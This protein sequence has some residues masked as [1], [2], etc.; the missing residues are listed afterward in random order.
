VLTIPAGDVDRVRHRAL[1]IR[2]KEAAQ[3]DAVRD[4]SSLR[5]QLGLEEFK[6]ERERDPELTFRRHLAERGAAIEV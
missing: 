1:E 4:G 5:E 2:A 6:R 3:A